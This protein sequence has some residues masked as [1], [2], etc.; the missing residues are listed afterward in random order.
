MYLMVLLKFAV[1]GCSAACADLIT[2][3]D[4]DSVPRNAHHAKAQST[5]RNFIIIIHKVVYH[6]FVC[7]F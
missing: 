6:N 4:Y 5:S 2:N 3:D 7:N 1:L